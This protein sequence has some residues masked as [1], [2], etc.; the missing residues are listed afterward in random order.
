MDIMKSLFAA[1]NSRILTTIQ[2]IY[3]T[4]NE[5]NTSNYPLKLALQKR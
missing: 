4:M 1:L 2:Y 5:Y 3:A